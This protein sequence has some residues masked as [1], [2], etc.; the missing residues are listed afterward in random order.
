MNQATASNDTTTPADGVPFL[1]GRTL[2]HAG[3]GRSRLGSSTVLLTIRESRAPVKARTSANARDSPAVR[4]NAN[5][6]SPELRRT[7]YL[8]TFSDL[9]QGV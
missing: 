8:S 2:I 4:E 5:A 6:S 9:R 7:P 3:P 1:S